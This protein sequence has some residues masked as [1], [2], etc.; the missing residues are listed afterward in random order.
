VGQTILRVIVALALAGPILS[1]CTPQGPEWVDEAASYSASTVTAVFDQVSEPQATGSKVSEASDLRHTAL[2]GLR[3]KGE[4][5]SEAADLITRTFPPT[6]GVPVYVERASFDDQEALLVVE[7]IGP[8]G[9]TLDDLRLW[10]LSSEG[11]VLFSAV[12]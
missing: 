9:G 8:D 11:A 5:A 3:R 4:S 10:V 6:A 2:V 1:G 12:D 7:L